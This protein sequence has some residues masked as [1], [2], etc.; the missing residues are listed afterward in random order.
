MSVIRVS[1]P[2]LR[3]KE[4]EGHRSAT[5]LE[6]F[7]DLV[8]VV[9]VAVLAVRLLGDSSGAGIATYFG[10]FAL[11]WWLWASHTFYADRYDTDDLVY[12]LL[13]AGQMA[14][15][16]I[17]AASLS[18][19]VASSTT[20]FAVGYAICRII[21]VVMYWR[22]YRHVHETRPLLRGYIY[23]FGLAAAIWTASAFV[24]NNTRYVLWAIALC[25]D[26]ATPWV[27]RIE[28]AKVPFD[29]SHLPERFGLFTILVLGE[30]IAAVVAGLAHVEWGFS[31]VLT[32]A[33]AVG[34]ATS[35]WW[36]YFD[37]ARGSVVRRDPSVRRT[38]RP[39]VWLYAHLPLAASLVSG[40]VALEHA[41][42]EAGHGP[43]PGADRWLLV[44][45]LSVS[46]ACFAL[47][48]LASAAAES[49]DRVLI[50]SRLLGIPF[51]LAIGLMSGLDSLWVA[52]G[53]LGVCVA[54][55]VADL[56]SDDQLD[57]GAI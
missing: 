22:A 4:E 7:Y 19:G 17:I 50:Y 5:W 26:L 31:P 43:M 24:P 6:L 23:G 34:I 44:T 30:S 35:L 13:A 51:L 38:W 25:I 20:A 57:E 1:P 8:F 27:M 28:Q 16:V 15:V 2:R 45:S 12:R 14:A 18:V 56:S 49:R 32:S 47:L 53:V 3:T 21:L 37:N 42:S 33:L 10:Y 48:H 52:V 46:L 11:I 55:V 39:T 40:G 9:A 36:L 29:V 41:V 54:E